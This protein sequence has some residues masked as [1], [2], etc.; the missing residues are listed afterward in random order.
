MENSTVVP[1]KIKNITIIGSSNSTSEYL[2]EENNAMQRTQHHYLQHLRY[3]SN[4]GMHP[5]IDEWVKKMWCVHT[6]TH[7]HTR[8]NITQP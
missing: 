6:H 2:P 1:Q 3:R 7:I 4:L 5:L 8:R